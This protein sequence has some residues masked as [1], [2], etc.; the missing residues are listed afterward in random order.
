MELYKGKVSELQK[1][2]DDKE[3][4]TK[5]AI[6]SFKAQS[7]LETALANFNIAFPSH[8]TTDEEKGAYKKSIQ[9]MIVND[10]KNKI[11]PKDHDGDIALYEG[12]T[13]HFDTKTGK[14]LSYL[15]VIKKHYG[16]FHAPQQEAPKGMGTNPPT[17]KPNVGK[18]TREEYYEYADSKGIVAGSQEWYKGAAEMVEL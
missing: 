10:L 6:L 1:A 16:A 14:N 13:L 9:S 12:D 4:S 17:P 8:L 3:E 5:N 15:D 2:L 18:M 7:N 11:T